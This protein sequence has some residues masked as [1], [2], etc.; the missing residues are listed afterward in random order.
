MVVETDLLT[1]Y[2][3]TALCL[4]LG[5]SW[6]RVR[7]FLCVVDPLD[8]LY[9]CLLLLRE[10]SSV[11]RML[12][13]PVVALV[14]LDYTSVI[15]LSTTLGKCPLQNRSESVLSPDLRARHRHQRKLISTT[16]VRISPI[17]P[18]LPN[19]CIYHTYVWSCCPGTA[20]PAPYFMNSR[21]DIATASM[22]QRTARRSAT[23][24]RRK[25]S[26]KCRIEHKL[27]DGEDY[28]IPCPACG[29]PDLLSAEEREAPDEGAQTQ[30]EAQADP[31]YDQL[32]W[33]L[34]RILQ[35]QEEAATLRKLGQLDPR[36]D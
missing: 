33:L 36:P 25:M 20:Q 5:K 29:S 19:M 4:A 22:K 10:L 21:C 15:Q 7:I 13:Y 30:R 6:Y 9:C 28:D 12:T 3:P 31:K 23:H 8:L 14:A 2:S 11:A 16:I 1:D 35:Q 17:T 27:L 24:Q 18:P 32:A 34:G 26:R